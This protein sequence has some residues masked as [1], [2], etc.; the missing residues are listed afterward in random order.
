MS[1]VLRLFDK[2]LGQV[3]VAGEKIPGEAAANWSSRARLLGA[4]LALTLAASASAQQVIMTDSQRSDIDRNSTATTVGGVLGAVV[5]LAA[6]KDSSTVVRVLGAALGATGGAILGDKMTSEPRNSDTS[7]GLKGGASADLIYGALNGRGTDQVAT[8]LRG[9]YNEAVVVTRAALDQS[10]AASASPLPPQAA[11]GLRTLEHETHQGIYRLMVDMVAYRSTA[12]AALHESERLQ[13]AAQVDPAKARQAEAAARLS[14]EAFQGYQGAFRKVWDVVAMADR[15]GY[16]VWHQRL[17]LSAV[18]PDLRTP[19]QA[20]L[21]WPG[22]ENRS[23]EVAQ[24]LVAVR[25][26]QAAE[27]DGQAAAR[28]QEL[29]V[30]VARPKA[31]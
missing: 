28:A 24:S 23:I 30:A 4:G 26:A 20:N 14:Q 29:R 1:K 11:D 19:V 12:V 18:P 27:I 10:V 3:A 16:D 6:T 25:S 8:S 21:R 15:A 7:R 31:R 17:S 5:G 22:V 13:L 9:R 2:T